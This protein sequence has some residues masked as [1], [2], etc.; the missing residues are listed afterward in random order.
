M[1]EV[2]SREAERQA[3]ARLNSLHLVRCGRF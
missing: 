2:G 3:H 1:V